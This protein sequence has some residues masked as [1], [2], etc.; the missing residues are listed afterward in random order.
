MKWI[1][2]A[3][4]ALVV[5]YTYLTLHYRK[6][7][8]AYRPY[9]ALKERANV[10]RLLA[11]GYRRINTLAERPADPQ[12]IAKILG[13]S[14]TVTDA[15]GGLPAGLATTLVETPLLPRAFQSVS[16]PREAVAFLP[17]TILFNCTLANQKE[18]LGG[19]Q[20]FV[21]GD[22]LVII[23]QFEPIEGGLI[24]RTNESV[25][26]ITVPAG[27]LKSGRYTVVLAASQHSKQ[28]TVD[29]K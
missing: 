16:A 9:E 14:A 23:P 21:R 10:E 7:G 22:T 27:T 24:A 1:V 18:Q 8:P 17:Y 4:I 5:P 6:P 11:A 29:V 20:V 2:I 26:T 3:I 25:V 19:S 13:A 12:R 28:W 15:P